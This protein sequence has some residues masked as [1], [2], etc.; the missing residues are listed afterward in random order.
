M[1]YGFRVPG[2]VVVR[3]IKG[4]VAS[5]MFCAGLPP[6]VLNSTLVLN[7]STAN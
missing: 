7:S 5:T 1:A 2:I 4:E 3:G 6:V